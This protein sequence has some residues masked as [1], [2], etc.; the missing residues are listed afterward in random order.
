LTF[1]LLFFWIFPIGWLASLLSQ[2]EIKKTMP[3]LYALIEDDERLRAFVQHS[4]PSAAVI[5]LN[6]LLPFI[7]ELLAYFEGLPARSWIEYSIMKRY[8]L[9]LLIN[10]IFIFLL[11]SN[12]FQVARDLYEAPG[13][14]PEKIAAALNKGVAKNYFVSYVMLQAFGI[15]PLQLLNLGVIIPRLFYRMFITRSPRDFAELNAPP[16]INYGAVYPQCILIFIITLLY[17]V[18]Q[19]LVLI[20]GT[21]YFGM[22][23]MVYKYKLLFVFYRPYESIGQAWP[24]TFIRAMWGTVLFQVF[25]A[26]ILAIN[27][28]YVLA[29]LLGPLI[30]FTVWWGWTIDKTFRPL[31][32]Y[33][34]L[35]SAAEVQRGE[36]TEEFIKLKAGHPVTR[37]QSN[38][39][40]RRY[41]QNDDTLYVAPEDEHTDYSQPPMTNWYNG[42]LNTGKRRYGHPALTGVLPTPWLPLKK[43]ET[44][45]NRPAENGFR[46]KKAGGEDNT[47]VLTL[48]RRPSN[49]KRR[50]RGPFEAN[51]PRPPPQHSQSLPPLGDNLPLDPTANPWARSSASL[52]SSPSPHA[53]TSRKMSHR[54]S[55][56]PASGIMMLPETDDWLE[57]SDESGSEEEYGTPSHSPSR[58]P[59]AGNNL[60]ADAGQLSPIA[61]EATDTPRRRHGIY[62]H[63]PERRASR[64]GLNMPG[65]FQ[66]GPSSL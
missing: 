5:G 43:G 3:W 19:P 14:I 60:F 35:C 37:S 10:V 23:Y 33:V 50:S 15:V 8:F 66:D 36:D 58:Q 42:V 6:A 9:F 13:K 57:E 54:L 2:K 1:V 63:H 21:I 61:R 55:Y 18:I 25:M 12:Y 27:K 31:S 38:L 24:I 51:S 62:F 4:I 40:R 47:L 34:S 52:A 32:S 46:R 41:A 45:V 26:G 44:L 20:F 29:G 48:R 64:L 59:S 28:A 7:L 53:S 49:L 17:G 16:M 39:S 65:E 11:V 56:D 30:L 22:S